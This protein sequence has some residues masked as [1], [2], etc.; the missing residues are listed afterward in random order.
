VFKLVAR[1][2]HRPTPMRLYDA[3]EPLT[4]HA[5]DLAEALLRDAGSL[6]IAGALIDVTPQIRGWRLD[7]RA[8]E[9]AAE[10]DPNQCHA[11]P[12]ALP[13]PQ[14]LPIRYIQENRSETRFRGRVPVAIHAA[15]ETY[16]G[17]TRDLSA[18]GL[19][20]VPADAGV[21]LGEG[22][23]LEVTFPSLESKGSTLDRMRGTFREVPT[24]VA[25]A[26]PGEEPRLRLR[27]IDDRR[28]RRFANGFAELV[29]Q[30]RSRLAKEVSH[31]LRAA[32]SR[33]YSSIFVESSSTVP[34]FVFPGSAGDWSFKLGLVPSPA[35]IVGFFEIADGVLD[36]SPLG[37]DGRLDR[38]M[39]QVAQAGSAE[40]AVYLYKERRT[41]R[42]GF[43]LRSWADGDTADEA[44]RRAF[45]RRAL[46]Q[47]FRCVKMAVARP[48]MPPAAEIEQAVDRLTRLSP[49]K[50]QRLTAEFANLQAIGDL[51]DITGLIQDFWVEAGSR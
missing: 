20:V 13:P 17:E 40:I 5:D 38:L 44:A 24:E 4:A 39:R 32:T 2:A 19:S 51:V 34:L 7:T 6:H 10:T 36:F 48:A 33:L 25:G 27:V 15:G 8:A 28:G 11:D 37:L 49:A 50:G 26:V 1:H 23:A 31:A 41:D 47:D 3:V 12:R 35:P 16:Q 46:G 9:G 21:P 30:R 29:T 22:A 42:P 18:H 43:V 45:I 14:V